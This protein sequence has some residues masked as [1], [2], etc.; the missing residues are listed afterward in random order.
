MGTRSAIA[1]KH[2]D[3]IKA[4]YCHW[5]GYIEHNGAILNEFYNSSPVANNLVALGDISS[6]GAAIGEEHEFGHRYSAEEYIKVGDKCHAAPQTTFYTRD[7]GEKD[8][9]FKSFG[10]EKEFI[11]YYD[12]A[13]CEYYYLMDNGVWYV[14]EYDREF[15]PLH[16]ALGGV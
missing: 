14:K 9:E 10:S 1:V 12:G 16:E 11:E 7:R 13:G 8:A 3:R 5:D 2:G 4:V 6:L 15:R